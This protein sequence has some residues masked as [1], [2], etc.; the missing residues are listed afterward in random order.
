MADRVRFDT[1]DARKLVYPDGCFDAVISSN[2]LH[3]LDGDR[4]REQALQEMLRVLKPGGRLVIFDTAET[5]YYADGA[6]RVWRAR[7]DTIG[8][9]L[10]VV[11]AFPQRR[12]AQA[13]RVIVHTV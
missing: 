13:K 7:C 4:E 8:L 1:V 3:T 9:D 12:R 11:P 5:G 2:A 10:A 6:P